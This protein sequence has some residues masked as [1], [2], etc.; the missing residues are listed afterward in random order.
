MGPEYIESDIDDLYVTAALV[1]SFWRGGGTDVRIAGEI[2]QR[3]ARFGATPLDRRRLEWELE[4]TEAE[5]VEAP[6]P[7]PQKPVADPR[8]SMRLVG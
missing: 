8:S 7:D 3:V 5:E 2:R 4:K 1:E 6:Q